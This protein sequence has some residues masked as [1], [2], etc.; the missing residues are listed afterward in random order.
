MMRTGTGAGNLS[1][2]DTTGTSHRNGV[3]AA[4]SI[5]LPSTL[6]GFGPDHVGLARGPNISPLPAPIV[7][8]R[9]PGTVVAPA[10]PTR[11]I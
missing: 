10:T 8:E 5:G 3:G 11:P 4:A 1:V 2:I 7:S 6:T 9:T